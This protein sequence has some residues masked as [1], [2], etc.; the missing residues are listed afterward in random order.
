MKLASIISTW[1]DTICL[2]GHCIEN[3]L[4]FSDVV[5]VVGSVKSNYEV[6]SRAYAEFINAYRP[7]NSRVRFESLEPTKGLKP[8]TN[9]TRKRNHGLKI[10]KDFGATHFLVADADEFYEPDQMNKLKESF[11]G[12]GYV[13]R[14]RAYITPTLYCMDHT[15]VA[16]IHRMDKNVFCGNYPYYPFTYSKNA[17]AH[18]DPSRRLSY[19]DGIQMSDILCH[20]YTLVRKDIDLKINNSTATSLKSKRQA[21][22]EEL[23]DAKPGYISRFYHKPLIETDNIFDIAL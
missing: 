6:S 21:I 7:V 18:I 1:A 16:G 17:I 11:K 3:H 4:Q 12:N 10:A 15:L 2:L 23:R 20:H 5:I 19:R 13:H 8:L 22:Y 9:E 14:V